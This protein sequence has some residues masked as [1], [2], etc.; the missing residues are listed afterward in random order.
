MKIVLAGDSTMA[1]YPVD[2]Q[3]MMGWGQ[4]LPSYLSPE[5]TVHNFAKNGSTTR[6]FIEEGRLAKL[7]QEVDPQTIV[8]LQFGH[9]DQKE[10]NKVTIEEYVAF[11]TDIIRRI[12]DKA[13][14]PIICTPVE[15]RVGD[16]GQ[17]AHTLSEFQPVLKE[18]SR[19]EEV[20]LF[21]LNRYTYHYYESLGL[22]ASKALFVWLKPGENP[23]Y[24]AG[25][26]DNTH[27]SQSGAHM[28]ARY[29]SIRLQAYMNEQSLF[30]NTYYGACM[31]P[32]VWS[33]EIMQSDI[34]TMKQI[35]MNFA[36]I[37]EFMWRD[38]EP[39]PGE[40][41]FE[42]LE[43]VLK[44]YQ[45]NGIDVCLCIPTPTP[46]RWFTK[47]YP[48]ALV[49]N[50]DGTK[51]H[52]G[53]R[54]HVCTNNEDFRRY[55]YR[56][57]RKIAEIAE[58]HENVVMLQ[59]DNEFKCHVDLCYCTSCQTRWHQYLKDT[60]QT[61]TNLNKRWGTTVWSEW[62][63][64]FDDVILPLA[65]PFLHNSSLMNAFRRFTTD[66]LNE[67]A[68]DLCHFI[69]METALPITHNSA[70]GFNLQNDELFA[71]LDVAGFDTYPP[72]DNYPAY[73][74]NLDRWRNVKPG[75]KEMLLL[76]TC[77]ANAGHI[78]NYASPRPR[79]FVTSEAFIG[80]AGNLKSFCFWHFRGHRFGVEQ[81]H[82]AVLTAWGEPDRG[83]EDV[84]R[85]GQLKKQI[86]PLLA[87]T[88]YV[89]AKIAIMYSD[90]SKRFYTIDHGGVY[91]YR[92]LFTE[93]YGSLIRQGISLEII[94]ENS[95]LEDYDVVLAPFV[96]W[97]SPTLLEKFAAFTDK[98]GKLILGPM[99]GDRTKELAWPATNGLDRLGE[100][101]GFDQIQQ[102]Q[103]SENSCSIRYQHHLE[104]LDRLVTVFD[105][106][107]DGTIEAT[108]GNRTVISKQKKGAGEVL[109]LGGVPRDL[110]SSQL[111]KD[112]CEK[113]IIPF[114]SD[115]EW[116]R[117]A[118]GLVKYRRESK[119]YIQLWI[120]NMESVKTTYFI[121]KEGRERLNDVTLTI[122]KHVL[123]PYEY[124]IIEWMK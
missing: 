92:G 83:Y 55:A 75:N 11:L 49:T 87:E 99:T 94:Q 24:P 10:K 15:R 4:A 70:F 106:R 41:D 33:E 28:V 90:Y 32:E 60:Y 104:P 26:A 111:W 110:R 81:P 112:F 3:P 13:G 95:P 123:A 118:N 20:A 5:V 88:T 109:Y 50:Q 117:T 57:T 52:H 48:E 62:Y 122:G 80:Y 38:L 67:F 40:Y 61:V 7:M 58:K 84:V 103:T 37:G 44:Q 115:R 23:N 107:I 27:F 71:D 108:V 12:K 77:T 68:H 31:Y 114:E 46:P 6:S 89:P 47:Q 93:F 98:G 35:G 91:D 105:L 18:L 74:M 29:V 22:E 97:I 73:T 2:Q 66:T 53:S 42:L 101:L 17:L 86:V 79:G 64:A 25:L 82:S 36:R 120:V 56:L 69:R 51:M 119:T 116:A 8:L 65:T 63:D 54:Q 76:E 59:L 121:E 96:R 21:D 16:E 43:R 78:E 34:Q 85:I 1:D 72:A 45:T 30:S 100:W 102:Y 19:I 124:Q 14:I 39:K 113:E 9:N